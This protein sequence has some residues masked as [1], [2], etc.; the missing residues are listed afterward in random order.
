MK[1][2]LPNCKVKIAGFLFIFIISIT[3]AGCTSI[4]ERRVTESGEV[5]TVEKPL[6]VAST[7]RFEDVPIPAGFNLMRD[8]S[9]IYQDSSIRVGLLRYAGRAN[10]AQII[11]FYKSQMSLYNW[12]LVNVVEFG[13]I[14]MSFVKADENCLI[15]IEPLTTK[16]LLN[17]V[18]SPK[19]GTL[20][21]GIGS[22]FGAKKDKF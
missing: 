8:Q 12:N 11:A 2:G 10:P 19:S 3:I 7:L 1:K 6:G 13:N 16:S 14:T 17:I 4:P 15:T 20:N 21:T 9:F 22:A 18:I 5:V